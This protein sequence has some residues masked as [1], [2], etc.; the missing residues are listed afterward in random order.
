MREEQHHADG[1]HAN[2]SAARR[3]H[4]AARSTLHLKRGVRVRL[5]VRQLPFFIHWE[6]RI[7]RAGVSREEKITRTVRIDKK[8]TARIS[9]AEF[10]STY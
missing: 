4:H 8:R 2:V 9:Q 1:V 6:N 3:L 5:N 10:M 7:R